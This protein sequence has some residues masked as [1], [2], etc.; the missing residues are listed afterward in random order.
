LSG[1]EK[2]VLHLANPTAGV[3]SVHGLSS[4]SP[5][6]AGVP[7]AK[8]ADAAHVAPDFGS[9]WRPPSAADP[10]QISLAAEMI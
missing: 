9:R 6:A 5:D 3:N 7:A 1:S 10:L 2:E 8:A 4:A